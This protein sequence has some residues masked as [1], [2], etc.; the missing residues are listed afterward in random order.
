MEIEKLN[1]NNIKKYIKDM[2]L[3]SSFGIEK[4]IDKSKEFLIKKDD[5]FIGSYLLYDDY[6]YVCFVKNAS[7][8]LISEVITSLKN[9]L[10]LKP[11]VIQITDA[12]N[13]EIMDRLYKLKRI[14]VSKVFNKNISQSS[15]IEK[16][17]NFNDLNIKYYDFGTDVYCDLEIQ[18]IND[19]EII[20]YLDNYFISLGVNAINF[21]VSGYCFDCV[22]KI[23]YTRYTAKYIID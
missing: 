17:V 10:S 15:P 5:M 20:K 1:E 16:Y 23:G 22:K 21:N 2:G 8:T 4:I 18:S 14:M 19:E 6:V 13:M 9:Q 11:L 7:E 12:K 3:S